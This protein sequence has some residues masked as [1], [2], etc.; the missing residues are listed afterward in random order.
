MKREYGVQLFGCSKIFREDTHGFFEK[1]KSAGITQIEPCI[2]FD[3]PIEFKKKALERGD[4]FA[5]TFPDVLWLPHE[6]K[7]FKEELNKMGMTLTS[8]HFFTA[9]ILDSLPKMIQVAKESGITSYVINTP[10]YA[11]ESPDEFAEIMTRVAAELKNIGVELW[12]HNGMGEFAKKIVF[13]GKE[14]PVYLYIL[15]KS[16]GV[17]GQIDTG[18]VVAGNTDVYEFIKNN[19][20]F[21]RGIHFKDLDKDY[22]NKSG[23]DIF[24]VLGEGV[25][26]VKAVMELVPHDMPI[27]IDQDVSKGDFV[28]DLIKSAEIIR[29]CEE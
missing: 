29:A 13:E 27:V 2:M 21:I 6:V 15:K 10:G 12:L 7:G 11:V 24:A 25:M 22:K 5:A 16:V 1:M 14:I 20:E 18:W 19:P 8:A 26:N 23:N 17:Y 9:S 28:A 3:D 4:T